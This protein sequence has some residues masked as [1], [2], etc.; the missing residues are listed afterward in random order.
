MNGLEV[1]KAAKNQMGLGNV[2]IV[3]LTTQGQD[4]EN[5]QAGEAGADQL[6]MKPLDPDEVY[7]TAMGILKRN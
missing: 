5:R 4:Y 1:C 6:L 3:M 7:D 2:H